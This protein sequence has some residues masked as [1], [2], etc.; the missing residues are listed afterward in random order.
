MIL[1]DEERA[2]F[3]AYLEQ[4]AHDNDGMAKLM[5]QSLPGAV[6]KDVV[7]LLRQDAAAFAYVAAKLRAVESETIEAAAA[8]KEE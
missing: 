1:T 2:K 7:K 6:P 4:Q 5:E 3:A 8:G